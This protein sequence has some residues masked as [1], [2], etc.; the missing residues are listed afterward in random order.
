MNPVAMAQQQPQ[1]QRVV[2]G[3]PPHQLM[4]GPGGM[5]GVAPN[6]NVMGQMRPLSPLPPQQRMPGNKN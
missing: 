1:Q 2:V 3:G 4:Q 5:V 6:I